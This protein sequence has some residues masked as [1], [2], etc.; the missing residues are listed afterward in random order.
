MYHCVQTL[1]PLIY[2]HSYPFLDSQGR[3]F[4]IGKVTTVCANTHIQ[5][6]HTHRGEEIR[7]WRPCLKIENQQW[8]CKV[9]IKNVSHYLK[10]NKQRKYVLTDSF[11]WLKAWW[12]VNNDKLST[13][14]WDKRK[15]RLVS[16]DEEYELLCESEIK[17][18]WKLALARL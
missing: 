15:R 2:I 8:F 18:K 10:Y 3:M 7:W 4:A 5:T 14:K 16:R 1:I 6:I 12:P 17:H 11:Y 9:K 13:E